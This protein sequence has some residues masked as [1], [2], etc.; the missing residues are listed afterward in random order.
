MK[1]AG[2]GKG[3]KER[4]GGWKWERKSGWKWKWKGSGKEKKEAPTGTVD[5]DWDSL[6]LGTALE[7]DAIHP[8]RVVSW[9][10]C[11]PVSGG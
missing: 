9:W 7:Q 3:G 6:R 4:R 8:G 2:A 11:G 5:W 1:K 10:V